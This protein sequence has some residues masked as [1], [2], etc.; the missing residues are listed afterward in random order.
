MEVNNRKNQ[1]RLA[2]IFG[3]INL[4]EL[5]AMSDHVSQILAI[6]SNS[7]V[8]AEE[9][10]EIILKDYSLTNKIL[11]V[12]NS[13][14]YSRGVQV[15]TIE[16]AVTIIGIDM[17]K[18]LAI[19]I[20]L[21]EEFIKSGVEKE[22][23]SKLLTKS[24][25]SAN[26]SKA[27]CTT[28]RITVPP[29]E[30]YVC[31]LLHKL[32]E[33]IILLYVPEI[34]N[35]IQEAGLRGGSAENMTRLLLKG[36]TFADIGMEIAKFWHFS[37]M[38]VSAMEPDPPIPE[39]RLDSVAIIQNL[40]VFSNRLTSALCEDSNL[41]VLMSKYQK[42]FAINLKE[43][44]N[45]LYETIETSEYISGALNYGLTKLKLRSKLLQLKSKL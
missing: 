24:F 25:L 7:K 10:A 3:K 6:S 9:L 5:P 32:G 43:V 14:F 11:Q 40:A 28:K 35:K 2:E 33:T 20:S 4:S 17:I 34:Y 27:V 41:D 16:R 45:I 30:A 39:S 42:M 38:I 29:E 44:I 37:D 18:E 12:V 1:E 23:I 31:T 21:F 8:T 15:T 13:P 19:S 36:H 26:L 22:G